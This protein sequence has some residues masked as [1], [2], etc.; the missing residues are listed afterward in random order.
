MR[1]EACALL[2]IEMIEADLGEVLDAP[3]SVAEPRAQQ[4]AALGK[5]GQ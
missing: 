2:L 1:R 4:H 3:R 5:I